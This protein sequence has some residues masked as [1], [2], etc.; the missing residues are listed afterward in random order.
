MQ[1]GARIHLKGIDKK[2]V[3]LSASSSSFKLSEDKLSCAASPAKLTKHSSGLGYTI[4]FKT[5][6]IDLK[7]DF[8]STTPTGVQMNDHY[9]KG[10]KDVAGG[11]IKAHF[12]PQCLVNGS[13]KIGGNAAYKM[14]GLGTVVFGIY[15]FC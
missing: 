3:N 10:E 13:I 4:E 5:E 12:L 8:V 11:F 9:F 14:D 15:L 6:D 7:V 2:T 1:I